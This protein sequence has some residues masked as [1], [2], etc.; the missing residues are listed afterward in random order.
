MGSS[1]AFHLLASD[2]GLSVVVIEKDHTYEQ[3][4]TVL[5]DGNVRIQFNLEENIRM[6]LHTLEILRTF[7]LLK[8]QAFGYDENS[9]IE[10]RPSIETANR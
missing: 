4:S 9:W 7:A 3:S 2:P 10:A 1:T 8:V 6:S 5:C